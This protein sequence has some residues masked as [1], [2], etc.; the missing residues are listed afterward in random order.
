VRDLFLREKAYAAFDALAPHGAP[1][2][3]PAA[4]LAEMM[5]SDVPLVG[6]GD[7]PVACDAAIMGRGVPGT[8]LA[9]YYV[10]AGNDVF[11]VDI[12]RRSAP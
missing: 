12:V 8:G 7:F 3:A 5:D 10:P 6:P 1:R 4:V 9:V 11:V 2:K